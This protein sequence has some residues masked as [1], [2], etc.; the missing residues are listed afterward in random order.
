MRHEGGLVWAKNQKSSHRGSVLVSKMWA[1]SVWG[2][3]NLIGAGYAGVEVM[4]GCDWVRRKGGLFWLK[5][6]N[7]ATGALFGVEGTLLGRDMLELRW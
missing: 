3:G 4:R 1:G 7:R 6:K 5:I 2:R